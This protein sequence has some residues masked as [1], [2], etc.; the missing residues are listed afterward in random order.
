[1]TEQVT[2]KTRHRVQKTP[3]HYPNDYWL[4]LQV[5]YSLTDTGLDDRPQ[6]A[7]SQT[8]WRDA[9]LEDLNIVGVFK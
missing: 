4:V 3:F 2:G 7:Y 6:S 9:K 8:Y 5:E 1:M